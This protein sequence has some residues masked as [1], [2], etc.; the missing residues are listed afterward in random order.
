MELKYLATITEEEKREILLLEE[1]IDALNE[2]YMG[3]DNLSIENQE[4][5]L[6]KMRKKADDTELSISKWWRTVEEKYNLEN[7]KEGMW[8]LNYDNNEVYLKK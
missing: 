5:L 2:L 6:E 1:R 3:F 4:M 7:S 8:T